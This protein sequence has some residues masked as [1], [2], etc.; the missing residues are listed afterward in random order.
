MAFNNNQKE[1]NLPLGSNNKRTSLDFLPKYYRTPANQKFLS[2]TLD[3][4]ISEGTVEKVNAFI[5]R[6][7]TPAYNPL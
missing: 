1:A 3:Q 2:A 5:G 4:L 6:K 7:N